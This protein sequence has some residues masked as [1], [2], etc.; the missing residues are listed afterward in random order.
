M[1][2]FGLDCLA[3]IYYSIR[4]HGD[5]GPG[6][7]LQC[8]NNQSR[9]KEGGYA[10]TPL[11]HLQDSDDDNCVISLQLFCLLTSVCQ[12]ASQSVSKHFFPFGY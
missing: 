6:Y 5:R 8:C 7:N 11:A 9:Q 3:F 4:M 10:R 12:G 1:F 2:C